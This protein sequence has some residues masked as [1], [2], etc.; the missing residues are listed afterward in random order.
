LSGDCNQNDDNY[1]KAVEYG[2]ERSDINVDDVEHTG[3]NKEIFGLGEDEV[4]RQQNTVNPDES[5]ISGNENR[6]RDGAAGLTDCAVRLKY[7]ARRR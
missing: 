3:E 7:S 6:Q 1:R 5:V 4:G 2:E